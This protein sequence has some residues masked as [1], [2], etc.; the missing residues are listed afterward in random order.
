MLCE[1]WGRA[2]LVIMLVVSVAVFAGCGK[3]A[4]DEKTA[5]NMMEKTLEKATGEKTD[6]N[7]EGGNVTIKTGDSSVEMKETSEWP[8]D[9]FSD[10][11]RFN[12]GVVERVSSGQE[13]GMTK[14]NVY[15]RDVADDAMEK[16]GADIKAAGWES[17]STMQSDEG[18][19]ISAQKGN[20]ALQF[21]YGK[22]DRTG[23][24]IAFSTP[25]E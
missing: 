5:E 12:Y 10:V 3:K 20:L 6:V 24:V 4:S 13:G 9:M 11:P 25:A 19:M 21:I 15:L 16:Y 14:F 18:G 8:A 1:R 22:K 2:L 7:I 17:Q 23:V